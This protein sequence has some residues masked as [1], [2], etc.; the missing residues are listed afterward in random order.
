[1]AELRE[2]IDFLDSQLVEL[3]SQRQR[4]IERAA[5]IKAHRHEIRD[6]ARI[7]DVLNKVSAAAEK[8]GLKV[9]IAQ[10][11]WREL[12]EGSI[13]LEMDCYEARAK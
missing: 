3:L 11:V 13:A 4:Y 12:M 7:Q 2:Q 6:E 9:E 10:R 1:M 8:A 5:E